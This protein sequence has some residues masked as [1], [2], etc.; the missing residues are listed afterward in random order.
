M[1]VPL[2]FIIPMFFA[3]YKIYGGQIKKKIFL[4]MISLL[5]TILPL[6]AR[7]FFNYLSK[8]NIGSQ[9]YKRIVIAGEYD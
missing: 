4:L 7:Q 6:V 2:I 5:F 9:K 1:T 8:V 3:L